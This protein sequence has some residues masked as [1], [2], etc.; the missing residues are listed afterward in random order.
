MQRQISEEA[1]EIGKEITRYFERTGK[2]EYG[3]VSQLMEE[4]QVEKSLSELASGM[5]RNIFFQSLANLSLWER[6]FSDWAEI[7]MQELPGQESPGGKS[8][9]KDRTNEI[10]SLNC[11]TC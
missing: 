10:M 2:P 7:L 5:N 6:N 1:G 9:G 11:M 4:A 8:E 3:Q